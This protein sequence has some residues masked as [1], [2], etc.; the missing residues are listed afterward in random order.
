MMF[1]HKFVAKILCISIFTICTGFSQ[2]KPKS[3]RNQKTQQ[4]S[5]QNAQ[6]EMTY[7]GY[8]TDDQLNPVNGSH[9][10]TFRFYNAET[11]GDALWSE[12]HENVNVI[13]GLFLVILGSTNALDLPFDE[14]YWL[15]IQVDDTAELTPRIRMTSVA[16]SLHSLTA[17]LATDIQDAIVTSS[18]IV[19]GSIQALDLGFSLPS[20]PINAND[21][22]DSAITSLKIAD[23]S[24]QALDLG[25]PLPVLPLNTDD[26]ADSAITS[27]KIADGS[28]LPFDLGFPLPTLPLNTED[29]AENAITSGKIA[30][31]SILP[32]DLGF[33]V[34]SLPIGAAD[35]ADS[36]ITGLKIA[37]G[38]IEPLDLGFPIP[39]LPISTIDIADG[40]ITSTKI[41]DNVI[42]SSHLADNSVVESTIA[43][44]A[45]T[46]G[47]I[48]ENAVTT[49]QLLDEPGIARGENG[50]G[51]LV[52][53]LNI[54]NV[55]S[56]TITVPG[57][58]FIVARGYGYAGL[59][60][61][62]IGNVVMG[63]DTAL[64]VMPNA[65]N[66]TL[67][68]SD[69]E[70]LSIS[71]TRW[72]SLSTERIF[73]ISEAGTHEYFL[74]ASR[75]SSTAGSATIWYGK[76]TLMYFPTSYGAVSISADNG[77]P[78]R[79]RNDGVGEK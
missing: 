26:I 3:P 30:D 53:L 14:Q 36:A 1:T 23:G 72:G 63:I 70:L 27:L 75:G 34:P 29:I 67:F 15:G 79:N 66:L 8:L 18:K 47:K 7:Q 77:V 16:T 59:T 73:Q 65:P 51:V 17:A 46:T 69:G 39:T 21:I 68:G 5:S 41:A 50:D 31:G 19:D 60:G 56:Q 33:S 43:N 57:P 25:F 71:L 52:D 4:I 20:L 49:A 13:S 24:I 9:N 78:D 38:S 12:T 22:A 61:L 62:S 45:I 55:A 44:A 6:K 48:A 76:L 35:I 32:L 10:L 58:G 42:N 11:G 28:I 2:E 40:S 64:S 74:N 54:T 37:D